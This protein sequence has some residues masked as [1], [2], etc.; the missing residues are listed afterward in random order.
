MQWRMINE[1]NSFCYQFAV[2]AVGNLSKWRQK[3]HLY[4]K[5]LPFIEIICTKFYYSRF[6]T[7]NLTKNCLEIANYYREIDV[8]LFVL[9]TK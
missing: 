6:E 9:C 5:T 3:L 7:P 8:I 4:S 1:L 2:F